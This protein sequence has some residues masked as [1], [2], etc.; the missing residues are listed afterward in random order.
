M[1]LTPWNSLSSTFKQLSP[2]LPRENSA[3]EALLYYRRA[4]LA[5]TEERY[6]V[7]LI[8]CAKAM[9]LDPHHLATRLLVAQIHDFGLHDVSAAVTALRKV[10]TSPATTATTPTAPPPAKPST[11][12]QPETTSSRPLP[13]AMVAPHKGGRHEERS[14]RPMADKH[15]PVL[16]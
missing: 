10:I 16:L 3:E 5:A 12:R 1:R 11:T 4:C 14:P 8:F 2:F 15:V 13:R 7:A 6:D 9:K